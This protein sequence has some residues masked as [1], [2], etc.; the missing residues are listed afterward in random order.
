MSEL[1]NIVGQVDILRKPADGL[2]CFREG[3]ATFENE[4]LAERRPI[5]GLQ[6]PDDPCV[7]SRRCIGRPTFSAA[8][9]R[10][11]LRSSRE[12]CKNCS[13]ISGLS[14]TAGKPAGKLRGGGNEFAERLGGKRP[15]D[16]R[17][18]FFGL[19]RTKPGQR[20]HS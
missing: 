18:C 19:F 13:A 12:S 3:R 8:I 9:A 1:T 14:Y 6:S 15:L 20:A 4:V 2:V 17:K 10:T 5:E 7:F 11:S 16:A